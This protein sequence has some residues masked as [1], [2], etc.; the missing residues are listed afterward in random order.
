MQVQLGNYCFEEIYT[1]AFQ[2]LDDVTVL[3]YNKLC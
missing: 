1:N 2:M 3:E